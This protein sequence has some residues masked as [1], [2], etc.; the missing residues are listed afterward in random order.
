MDW[1]RGN[2]PFFTKPPQ[3]EE[4]ENLENQKILEVDAAVKNPIEQIEEE[5]KLTDAQNQM[6]AFLSGSQPVHTLS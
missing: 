3:N 2:L 6:L 4:A 5:S 1:Q